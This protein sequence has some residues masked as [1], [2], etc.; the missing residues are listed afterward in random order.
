MMRRHIRVRI[1][2]RKAGGL[3]CTGVVLA[4]LLLTACGGG[5][6][7]VTESGQPS[8]VLDQQVICLTEAMRPSPECKPGQ[9]VAFLPTTFGNEQM[10]VAFATMNCDLRYAVVQ[11]SGGVTCIFLPAR[12]PGDKDSAD[13][14]S[15]PDSKGGN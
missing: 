4:G 10:P 11:T 9:R 7:P 12:A 1:Q 5:T 3:A 8:G 13:A 14:A 6:A 15:A 2:K